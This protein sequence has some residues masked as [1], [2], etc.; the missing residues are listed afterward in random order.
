MRTVRRKVLA[1][2]LGDKLALLLSMLL[3]MTILMSPDVKI[4]KM[5]VLNQN[6]FRMLGL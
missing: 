4:M 3:A 1:R 2:R 6:G 5:K